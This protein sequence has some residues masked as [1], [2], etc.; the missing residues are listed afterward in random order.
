MSERTASPI[1]PDIT[2]Q[3]VQDVA[4][5]SIDAFAIGEMAGRTLFW[6][7]EGDSGV[8]GVVKKT[9]QPRTRPS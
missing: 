9:R 5:V 1:H 4:M 6:S 3:V 2:R 8:A 7:T